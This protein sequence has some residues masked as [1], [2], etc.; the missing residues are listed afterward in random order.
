[1]LAFKFSL[2]LF[3]THNK[4]V[5][6]YCAFDKDVYI[7]MPLK[8]LKCEER[9]KTS[10]FCNPFTI[11]CSVMKHS[12]SQKSQSCCFRH[13]PWLENCSSNRIG[14]RV[15]TTLSC[16]V[17]YSFILKNVISVRSHSDNLTS[18][19]I[20]KI[21]LCHMITIRSFKLRPLIFFGKVIIYIQER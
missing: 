7:L 10:S 11:V 18:T 14:I 3:I 13:K 1:M 17:H 21:K 15:K 20:N 5:S 4:S 19:R 6:L 9:S 8:V 2:E 16:K 12:I